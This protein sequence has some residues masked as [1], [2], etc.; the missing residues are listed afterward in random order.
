MS[1]AGSGERWTAQQRGVWCVRTWTPA[2]RVSRGLS[3]VDEARRQKSLKHWGR[4]TGLPWDAL[5]G[6]TVTHQQAPVLSPWLLRLLKALSQFSSGLSPPILQPPS[7]R[8]SKRPRV[9]S[10]RSTMLITSVT[11]QIFPTCPLIL[12]NPFIRESGKHYCRG[13]GGNIRTALKDSGRQTWVGSTCTLRA[14]LP[15]FSRAGFWPEARMAFL[16]G[17]GFP[18]LTWRPSPQGLHHPQLPGLQCSL[19]LCPLSGIISL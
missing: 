18:G 11:Q 13:T 19:P 10:C 16:H 14:A 5:L 17:L 9:L 12:I 3:G 6:M 7:R 8:S 1:R 2:G 15:T 4:G